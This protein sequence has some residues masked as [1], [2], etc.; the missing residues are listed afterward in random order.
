MDDLFANIDEA[1]VQ[2]RTERNRYEP[3]PWLEHTGWERHLS[4]N[5][6][7]WVTEFVKAEPNGEN[8][9]GVLGE[10]ES[11]FTPQQEKALSR[12]CEGT[13]LLIRLSFQAS[14]IEIVGRHALYCVNRRENGVPSNDTST[15]M[16]L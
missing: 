16:F 1:Q 3:N 9:R 15:P 14:R 11:R 7:R 4:I 13:V 5:H 6:R 10:D 2:A 8:V 12:V